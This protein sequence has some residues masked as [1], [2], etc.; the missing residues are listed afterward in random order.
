MRSNLLKETIQKSIT[1][2]LIPNRYYI[3]DNIASSFDYCLSSK[4]I[5]RTKVSQLDN[6]FLFKYY[7]PLLGEEVKSATCTR[8]SQISFSLLLFSSSYAF[9]ISIICDRNGSRL[10][11][12]CLLFSSLNKLSLQLLPCSLQ[13]AAQ[14]GAVTA[15]HAPAPSSPSPAADVDKA[16]QKQ[17]A[18][19]LIII[20]IR[21]ME[22]NIK[23]F[24]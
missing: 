24:L 3:I 19:C 21:G 7:S 8:R 13:L 15:S 11:L 22:C 5:V 12:V 20:I 23:H 9:C 1:K 10:V 18:M 4:N 17:R 16:L 2:Q 6:H 14:P